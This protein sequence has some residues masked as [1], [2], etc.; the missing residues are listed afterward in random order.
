MSEPSTGSLVLALMLGAGIGGGL[1][2]LLAW[3]R[4]VIVRRT[5]RR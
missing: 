5:R 3:T 4:N 2:A 1:G